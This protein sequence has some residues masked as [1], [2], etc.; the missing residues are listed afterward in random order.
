M[1]KHVDGLIRLNLLHVFGH[2]N[3]NLEDGS[4]LWLD[5]IRQVD[6]EE[7]GLK[8]MTFQLESKRL[9]YYVLLAVRMAVAESN[10]IVI[11]NRLPGR[12][13]QSAGA[14]QN[15]TKGDERVFAMTILEVFVST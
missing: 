12:K 10:L 7:R 4:R 6:Q 15:L 11:Y 1:Q 5:R 9:P 2:T 3:F 8:R 13:I 14:V